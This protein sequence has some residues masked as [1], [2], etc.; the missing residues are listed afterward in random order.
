MSPK[1]I[2]N[3]L[4]L[5][6]VIYILN[7]TSF[8][9][10]LS[11]IYMCGFGSVFRIQTE[12]APEYGSKMDPDSQSQQCWLAWLLILKSMFALR[13]VA[14]PERLEPPLFLDGAGSRSWSRLF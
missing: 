14:E 6:I 5:W 7:L 4:S 9:F 2:F 11:Y 8:A 13:S 1:E 10:I 3:Q 12:K